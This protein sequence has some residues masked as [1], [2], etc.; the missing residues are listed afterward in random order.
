MNLAPRLVSIALLLV[1][2]LAGSHI[3]GTRLLPEPQ[4]PAVPS[5][6]TPVQP[7]D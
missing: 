2:W 3:I 1:A 7:E 6:W 5:L 4:T